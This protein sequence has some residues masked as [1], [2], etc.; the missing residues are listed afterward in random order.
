MVHVCGARSAMPSVPRPSGHPAGRHY[1]LRRD[2]CEGEQ[3]AHRFGLHRRR[4][5][6]AHDP[7]TADERTLRLPG[8]PPALLSA[9]L[10]FAGVS[11]PCDAGRH[12]C[13]TRRLPVTA[14]RCRRWRSDSAHTLLE[15]DPK[16]NQFVGSTTIGRDVTALDA[17]ADALWVVSERERT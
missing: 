14:H 12:A 10:T 13:T 8:Q 3:R 5:P 2:D 7:K 15:L 17:T 1:E 11:A 6:R 4:L 9:S 16:T